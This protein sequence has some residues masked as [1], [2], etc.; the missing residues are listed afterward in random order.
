MKKLLIIIL[1]IFISCT[2]QENYPTGD[3]TLIFYLGEDWRSNPLN[4]KSDVEEL[5]SKEVDITNKRVIILYD[6]NEIGDTALYTLDSPFDNN[7]R[8]IKL[9]NTGIP[10]LSKNETNM[11]DPLV[12]SA[13]I[14]YV[15]KKIPSDYYALYIGGHGTGFNSDF[16]SSLALETNAPDNQD[17][18]TINELSETLDKTPID[19]LAFDACLMGNLENIYQ[20]EGGTKY[21]VASPEN[22]P[23]P[24]NNYKY[25][26]ENF[27]SEAATTPLA[28]GIA[29]LNSYYR[30]YTNPYLSAYE[31]QKTQSPWITDNKLLQLYDV[32]GIANTI[33]E[34]N[35]QEKLISEMENS[36]NSEYIYD[37][38]LKIGYYTGF[39]KELNIP[40]VD[41]YIYTA[42]PGFLKL[43]SVYY[44]GSIYEVTSSGTSIKTV[45]EDY[46]NSKFAVDNPLWISHLE[47]R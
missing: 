42:D 10:L 13:F 37:R 28:L 32:D 33:R 6:G 38:R 43:I 1:P 45:N 29:T 20:L 23:G 40:E 2:L 34:E 9:E 12:L 39:Y 30:G 14:K 21:I 27:Y 36:T 25:L 17:L 35:F 18:L 8:E 24:G 41:N 46:K 31:Q 7:F 16:P 15:K 11:G 22:I 19:L 44:P 5:T 26:I 47:A 3:S 4:L